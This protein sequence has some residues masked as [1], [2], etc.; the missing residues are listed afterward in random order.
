MEPTGW[1]CIPVMT[2]HNSCSYFFLQVILLQKGTHKLF[3]YYIAH[4]GCQLPTGIWE[5]QLPSAHSPWE[6]LKI[7]P[8]LLREGRHWSLFLLGKGVIFITTQSVVQDMQSDCLGPFLEALFHVSKKNFLTE[9][10][11]VLC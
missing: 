8:L 7:T 2:S 3:G 10:I 11:I 6:K 5:F 4:T 9:L 1:T